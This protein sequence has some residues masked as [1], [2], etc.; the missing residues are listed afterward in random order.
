MGRYMRYLI[1]FGPMAYRMYTKW[2][3]KNKKKSIEQPRPQ[4]HTE[5]QSPQN[6]EVNVK[7]KEKDVKYDGDEFV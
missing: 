6:G 1:M 5:Q 3:S 4:T 7:Y 2:A